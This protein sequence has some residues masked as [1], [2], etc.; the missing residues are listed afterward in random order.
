MAK[1]VKI[2]RAFSEDELQSLIDQL[3][4]GYVFS[5]VQHSTCVVNEK[6]LYTAVVTYDDETRTRLVEG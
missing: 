6:V 5:S 2:L 4:E 1:R 3:I